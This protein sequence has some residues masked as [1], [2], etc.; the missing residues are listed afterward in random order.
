MWSDECYAEGDNPFP[1]SMS[2]ALSIQPR[3]Y[4]APLLPG[5][6]MGIHST[7][8]PPPPQGFSCRATLWPT[9][10]QPMLLQELF[11]PWDRTQHF[12]VLNFMRS[13]RPTPPSSGWQPCPPAYWLFPHFGVICKLRK[14][15]HP[16]LLQINLWSHLFEPKS[17]LNRLF[18]I[19]S[20][21][22]LL[23]G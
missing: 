22:E 1:W 5:H 21:S 13:C 10:P 17:I 8:C 20:K 16:C 18:F 9:H 15:A 3:S 11:P 6:T 19:S 2:W 4:W 23:V 14:H 7:H 12:S